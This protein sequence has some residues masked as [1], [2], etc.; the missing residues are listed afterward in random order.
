MAGADV[1]E[2]RTCGEANARWTIPTRRLHVCYE[3][4]QEFA[5]LY[6]DF[7]GRTLA[8]IRMPPPPPN[9]RLGVAAAGAQSVGSWRG[10]RGLKPTRRTPRRAR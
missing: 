10:V 9:Q 4:A 8:Q 7:G 3:L 6:R 5:E 2:M 1:M